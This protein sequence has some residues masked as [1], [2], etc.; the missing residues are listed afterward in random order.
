MQVQTEALSRALKLLIASGCKFAVIDH[1]GAKHGEL[2][3]A[4]PKPEPK[5]KPPKFGRGVLQGYYLPLLADM[6]AGDSKVIPYGPFGEDKESRESLRG[7]LCSHC[8]SAWGN[9]SYI[10][11]MNEA[12][13]ELLRVE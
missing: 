2:H 3:V 10:S 5:R 13:I 9:K 6:K 8:S 1:T 7:A 12:G 4:E 11:H